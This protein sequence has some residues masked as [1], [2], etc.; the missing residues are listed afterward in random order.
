[1]SLIHNV[2]LKLTVET[3][4]LE[5]KYLINQSDK[6]IKRKLKKRLMSSISFFILF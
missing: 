2:V 1:M 3:I 6:Y 4:S 5:I